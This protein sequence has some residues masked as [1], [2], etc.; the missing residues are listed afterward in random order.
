MLS[1]F[2][3]NS[4]YILYVVPL[5]SLSQPCLL[6][7]TLPD[8]L[9]GLPGEPPAQRLPLTPKSRQHSKDHSPEDY[10][11]KSVRYLSLLDSTPSFLLPSDAVSTPHGASFVRPKR[12]DAA[13]I[14][15]RIPTE[16]HPLPARKITKGLLNLRSVMT[17]LTRFK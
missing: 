15:N 13:G 11:S 5:R 16:D 6:S 3:C 14:G 10:S 8:F 2:Q 12:R 1:Y 4:N 9:K 7:I 17:T